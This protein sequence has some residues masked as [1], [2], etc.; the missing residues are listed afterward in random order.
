MTLVAKD[1]QHIFGEIDDGKVKMTE[2]GQIAEKRWLGIPEHYPAAEIDPF[3]IMPNHIH[4]IIHITE[5]VTPI[6]R[7]QDPV[8]A[9]N[10]APQRL[11]KIIG[12]YKIGVT[13]WARKNTKI[14]TV[15]Q[16]SFFDHIV[17]N[18][19]KLERI[20]IYM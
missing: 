3:I 13:K 10:P 11:G 7:A 15:W 2:L 8:R 12:G 19:L 14:K 1:R 20:R 4:G 9:Q 5:T 17:R 18:D 16:R 6:V